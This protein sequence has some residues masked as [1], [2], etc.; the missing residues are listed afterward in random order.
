M[1][2][3][4]ETIPL[5]ASAMT[6]LAT[7]LLLLGLYFYY[8]Q[9]SA[10][11]SFVKKVRTSTGKGGPIEIE[12]A[13][14]S[15]EE[16]VRTPI[17]RF[18]SKIG[19]RVAPVK[20]EDYDRLKRRLI[21]GG[22]RKPNASTIFWGTKCLLVLLLPSLFF[23]AGLLFGRFVNTNIETASYLLLTLSGF[24]L[25]DLWLYNRILRRQDE[26]RKGLPDSLDL[27]VVCVEAGMGLDSAIGRVA[28]EITLTHK[29]LGEELKLY[30]LEQRAGKS[31]EAALKS[32][33]ARID[34]DDVDSLVSLLVQTDKFG[35]S[36][37]QAL[38]VYSDT[39][40]TKRYMKAEEIA[41]RLGAKLLFPLILFIFPSLFVAILGPA[42]ITLLGT[43][44][45]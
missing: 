30:G 13:P 45:P 2:P 23:V 38:R 34:I 19:G 31:R 21:T 10:K 25:P 26:I 35:T 14:F 24:Y 36:L 43:T 12:K 3:A 6:F 1:T 32:F 11:R 20:S 7:L 17:F 41:A 37:A 4:A 22:V 18:L 8:R 29:T 27:L 42:M 5:V 40:R 39:F 44:M 28:G 16:K 33:G 9:Y 15:S